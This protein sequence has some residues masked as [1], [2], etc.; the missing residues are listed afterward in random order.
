M[1]LAKFPFALTSRGNGIAPTIAFPN[2]VWERGVRR[3]SS[4]TLTALAFALL[5][6]G[7]RAD[8]QDQISEL[9]DLKQTELGFYFESIRFVNTQVVFKLHDSGTRY[10]LKDIEHPI[11]DSGRITE[12]GEELTLS[13]GH[14]LYLVEKHGSLKLVSK[15]GQSGPTIEIESSFNASDIGGMPSIKK[16]TLVRGNLNGIDIELLS[17]GSKTIALRPP[18]PAAF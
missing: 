2:R 14:S 17:D 18:D 4:L 10:V 1:L 5:L 7:F 3:F 9:R 16:L 15:K 6:L 11:D 13:P 12:Y 8:G